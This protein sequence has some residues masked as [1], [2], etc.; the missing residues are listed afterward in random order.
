MHGDVECPLVRNADLLSNLVATRGEGMMAAHALYSPNRQRTA[1]PKLVAP[2]LQGC[3][4]PVALFTPLHCRTLYFV[5]FSE[6]LSHLDVT[7][8]P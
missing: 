3:R 4:K 6:L 2:R 5:G 8:N 7:S 1:G